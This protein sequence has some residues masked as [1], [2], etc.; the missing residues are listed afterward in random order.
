MLQQCLSPL[1]SYS[2]EYWP[3]VH[4]LVQRK[5][6]FQRLSQLRLPVPQPVWVQLR[7]GT[8]FPVAGLLGSTGKGGQT[9]AQWC[10]WDACPDKLSKL[11]SP[12]HGE[13]DA[14]FMHLLLRCKGRWCFR[15][16]GRQD[17]FDVIPFKFK[18]QFKDQWNYLIFAFWV[19]KLLKSNRSPSFKKPPVKYKN[20]NQ[21]S[22]QKDIFSQ[23][24]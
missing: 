12:K 15:V 5:R 8:A 19:F 16:K 17:I 3:W 18:V 13:E 4:L 1:S 6:W 14:L 24:N 9:H 22:S 21:V 20:A 11:H 2:L 23:K 7:A 10:G